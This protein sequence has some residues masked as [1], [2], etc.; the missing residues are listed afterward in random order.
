MPMSPIQGMLVFHFTVS[1]NV[2]AM[3]LTQRGPPY[4]R[5]HHHRAARLQGLAI[6]DHYSQ[7]NISWHSLHFSKCRDAG[8]FLLHRKITIRL[9]LS[10]WR[11]RS[12][13][14]HQFCGLGIISAFQGMEMNKTTKGFL[15][16]AAVLVSLAFFYLK[17][18]QPLVLLISGIIVW[19]FSI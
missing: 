9:A 6:S 1:E 11:H 15:M 17:G 8:I 7:K 16:N 19:G 12:V 5:H 2:V 14:P 18:T 10:D 13:C 3:Q 4:R